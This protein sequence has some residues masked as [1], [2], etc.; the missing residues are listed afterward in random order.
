MIIKN[1]TGA[2]D[3]WFA[4]RIDNALNEAEKKPLRLIVTSNGGSVAQAIAISDK[5]ARHGN[6][7]VEFSGVAASAATW[8]AFGANRVEMHEDTL[9]LCHQCS[10][11]IIAWENMNADEL[12][13]FIEKLKNEKKS[14]EVIDAIIAKKYLDRCSKK[15]KSLA[16]IRDL[17]KE[18][19]YL[20]PADCLEWGFVDEILPTKT[21]A[22]VVNEAMLG[23][24]GLPLATIANEVSVVKGD[25]E[26]LVNRIIEGVK[27]LFT[28]KPA[29]EQNNNITIIMNKE[30][31]FINTLLGVEG[32]EQTENNLSLSVEHMKKINAKLEELNK[33][34][35]ALD[36]M[37]DKIAAMN[38]ID[39]KVNAIALIIDKIPVGATNPVPAK[40]EEE[41]NEDDI[42]V[43]DEDPVNEYRKK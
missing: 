3:S 26:S 35:A 2:I 7:T 41:N 15:N 16:D 28:T 36:K 33:A 19:R 30:F 10:A 25:D 21:A 20:A 23:E 39:N 22:N 31:T 24:M 40:N 6:V 11:P 18:E 12:D 17:M 9:W 32:V 38:G 27:N 43:E 5:L 42:H 14:L 34:N 1:I 13:A 4:Y 37:S 8:M 29:K